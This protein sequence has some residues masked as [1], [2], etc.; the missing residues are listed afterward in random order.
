M[1]KN[2]YGELLKNTGILTIGNL[3]TKILIF[4]LVP[5]Y[6][7]ALSTADYGFYD[8][9]ISTVQLLFPIFSLNIVDS[10][11]RFILDRQSTV[12]DIYCVSDKLIKSGCIISFVLISGL[13]F[14]DFYKD[15]RQYIWILSLYYVLYSYNSLFLQVAQG[16]NRVKTI[17]ITGILGAITLFGS[18]AIFLLWFDWGLLGFYIA[19]VLGQAIPAIYYF[20]DLKVWQYKKSAFAAEKSIRTKMLQYSVPLIVNTVCW[21]VNSASDKYVVTFLCDVSVNGLLSVAYKI[22]N[23]LSTLTGIFMQ[24]WQIS[25]IKEYEEGKDGAFYK[26]TFV[27]LNMLVSIFIVLCIPMTKIIARYLFYADF[28]E[29]WK[30]VPILLI[31]SMFNASSG[32]I[33]PILNASYNTKSVAKSGLYGMSVNIILN[34]VFTCLYGAQGITV[35]TAISSLLI[36]YI[37]KRALKGLLN[38][39]KYKKVICTW[40]ILVIHSVIYVYTSMI[41]INVVIIILIFVLYAQEILQLIK[42]AKYRLINLFHGN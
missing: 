42:A 39:N 22:P 2:K 32:Y 41:W 5:I 6:T 24:A 28:Y 20:F 18:T 17:A 21:W 3:S 37:R 29:A 4:F 10:V 36:F 38:G 31:S 13:S 11:L 12:D 26:Q 23:I 40:I 9:T 16:V 34:I 19:N 35:A 7:S 15:L 14:F 1:A 8:L 33:A 27:Y 25:A 30:F